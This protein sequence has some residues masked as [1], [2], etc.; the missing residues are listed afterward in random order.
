MENVINKGSSIK[1]VF[2]ESSGFSY[3]D[4]LVLNA[5]IGSKMS[6]AQTL[7][8]SEISFKTLASYWQVNYESADKD[9]KINEL[10][11]LCS[12]MITRY[13]LTADSS[14]TD[15]FRML[16][17]AQD[18]HLEIELYGIVKP[19]LKLLSQI[20]NTIEDNQEQRRMGV[21]GKPFFKQKGNKLILLDV[22]WY[23]LL[24]DYSAEIV[25]ELRNLQKRLLQ[26][27]ECIDDITEDLEYESTM[28]VKQDI[29]SLYKELFDIEKR[30]TLQNELK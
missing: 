15:I 4:I 3:I 16:S 26:P 12:K 6:V 19:S 1:G 22:S 18:R 5:I 17:Y 9:I 13:G 8:I 11:L 10:S 14:E 30:I 29:N 28:P 25:E 21:F 23:R 2:G 27:A 20:G 24:V 7:N